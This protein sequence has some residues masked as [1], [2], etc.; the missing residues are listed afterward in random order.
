MNLIKTNFIG[1]V[2]VYCFLLLLSVD[3]VGAEIN[4]RE[5]VERHRVIINKVNP[6]SPSQVGNGHFAFGADIT[7]LQT[8][9]PFNILADWSWHSFPMPKATKIEDFQDTPLV[10]YDKI[11]PYQYPDHNHPQISSW[12][13]ENPHRFN[14][15]RIGFR[16][17]KKDGTEA[18]EKDLSQ[19]HQE[20]DLWSGVI[21]SHFFLEGV[22]VNVKTFCSPSEDRIGTMVD[23]ELIS[24]G[25]LGIFIDFPY[26]QSNEFQKYLGRYDVPES[27]LSTVVKQTSSHLFIRRQLDES[28]YGVGVNWSGV[29]DVLFPEKNKETGAP[30]SHRFLFQP[31]REESSFSMT[32][33][34]SKQNSDEYKIS[35]EMILEESKKAWEKY[36]MSGAA[37]DLSE[38]KDPRWKE[39][40]RRIVLSQYLMRVNEAGSLPPQESGL[41]NNG[42]Y[43]R[44]HFEMI[45]WHGVHYGLWGRWEL[46]DRYL[47]IYKKFLPTSIARARKQGYQGARWPKCTGDDIDRDW[48]HPIHATLIWQQPHPI[49]F[50]EMDYRLHPTDETLKKWEDIVYQ[51]AD[52]MADFVHYDE[53]KDRFV[54]GPPIYIVSENTDNMKT[55]NPT[56]ELGYWSYGLR[57][58]LEWNKRLNKPVV[59]KWKDVLEKLSALPQEDGVYITHEGIQNMW[60]K[61]TFEHPALIGVFGMLPGDGVENDVFKK[62]LERVIEKWDFNRTWG[63]DFPMIAMAAMRSGFPELAVD[64]L[65]HPSSGFQFNEHGLC[66]GGPFPYFPANGGLLTAVAMMC[67]GWDGNSFGEFPGFPKDGSWCIKAENFVQSQ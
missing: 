54:L 57:V 60:T 61:F 10:V 55:F 21:E 62:T 9:I 15:G 2:F 43:G 8:F 17:L 7:G 26:P 50:A 24:Q 20:I 64:F 6:D 31:T 66:T 67:A 46:F 39:L 25:R 41:V 18:L 35:A 28:L 36:W 49:Y 59:R 48:P 4:R 29:C 23:S 5:L 37:V 53:D 40:E 44:Y 19:T 30:L 42:W 33:L 56:F 12:M 38:S 58:A 47:E 51:T 45:W 3:M 65:L 14:L 34:F 22:A 13:A 27:H 32:F 1:V 52:F 63:W 11:V 16:L